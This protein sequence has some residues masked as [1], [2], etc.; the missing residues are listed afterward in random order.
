M[1]RKLRTTPKLQTNEPDSVKIATDVAKTG[2]LTV[3]FLDPETGMAIEIQNVNLSKLKPDELNKLV[4]G[5]LNVN[6]DQIS[7]KI[8][9]KSEENQILLKITRK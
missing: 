4:A 5:K 9:G 7:V 1:S 8:L 2:A 3:N 6:P